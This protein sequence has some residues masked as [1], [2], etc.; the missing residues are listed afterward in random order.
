MGSLRGSFWHS[1]SVFDQL[2][3]H[4]FAA[5]SYGNL[6]TS[7]GTLG[8]GS[9]CGAGAP[10]PQDTPLEFLS[11]KCGCGTSPLQISAP[12][13]SLD[14]CVLF[15]SIGV[16]LLFNL[17]F[18]GSEWWLFY[19][20]VVILMCLC[21]E[22]GCIYLCHHL[23][24]NSIFFLI[25][26]V[27]GPPPHKTRTLILVQSVKNMLV[28]SIN[29]PAWHTLT[30]RWRKRLPHQVN[31]SYSTPLL[32]SRNIYWA[33]TVCQE[34]FQGL[35]CIR[36]FNGHNKILLNRSFFICEE[37]E[38]QRYLSVCPSLLNV[39]LFIYQLSTTFYSV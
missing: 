18:D 11:T 4:C 23:D 34:L 36:P 9:S 3:P 32:H 37:T 16:R 2:N 10:C 33:L 29:F 7:T 24:S 38:A 1:T 15:N 25:L 27:I 17:I 39:Y 19:S 12:P 35:E 28:I 8:W 31:I 6:S 30:T 13:T 20:L 22:A 21:K 26:K 14:E 5:R